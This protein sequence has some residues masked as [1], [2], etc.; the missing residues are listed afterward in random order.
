M[1]FAHRT[2]MARRTVLAFGAA[3]LCSIGTFAARASVIEDAAGRTVAVAD[4]HRIVSI[5]G[6]VTEILYAL[7]DAD[8]IVAVDSTSLYPPHA[9]VEKRNVGYMRQL[10]A[11]GV[12]GLNPSLVLA[13]KGSGPKETVAVL[14]AARVPFVLVPESYTGEG[15]VTKVRFIARVIGAEARGACLEAAVTRDLEALAALRKRVTRPVKV[16]FVL[17]L[18]EGRALVAGH[19]TAAD[20]IIKLA[21]AVNAIDAY[22]GYKPVSDEAL[23]A[24]QPD[25]VLTMKRGGQ[26]LTADQVFALPAFAST[27]AATRR[28]FIAMDGLYLLGFGPRTASAARDLA[29]TLYPPLHAAV[30]PVSAVAAADCR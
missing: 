15:V 9:L 10:S 17:S 19:E 22:A 25:V 3:G 2:G 7:G 27:P 30:T 6:S 13:L 18:V 1:A 24:A 4:T 12:L 8:H 26:D 20:G 16:M 21:G 5:G 29:G 14:E 23:I 28:A 11:E